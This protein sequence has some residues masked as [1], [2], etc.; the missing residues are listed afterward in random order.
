MAQGAPLAIYN[1]L[2]RKVQEFHPLIEG[3]VRVYS[4][5]P[6]VSRLSRLRCC[7]FPGQADDVDF[8]GC[9]LVRAR[10]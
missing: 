6:T 5:G 7:C 8:L 4:C 1:S 10:C 2:T 9:R 3:R